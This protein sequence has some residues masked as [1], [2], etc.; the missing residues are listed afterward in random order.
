MTPLRE[1]LLTDMQAQ[2]LPKDIQERYVLE[3]ATLA[4]QTRKSPDLVAPDELAEFV[5]QRSKELSPAES[6]MALEALKFF[7]TQTLGR[8]WH[9]FPEEGP[10]SSQLRLRMI[11]DMRLRNLSP[12][13][14]QEYL[15]WTIK[16]AEFYGQS[17]AKLGPEDIRNWLVHLLEKEKK[18]I[19]TYGVAAAALRFL[20]TQTLGRQ[21]LL[22]YIPL[23]KREKRLPD[24]LSQ[25]E[26]LVFLN[27]ELTLRE[28][29]VLS[30]TY[31]GGL[32]TTEVSRL[33][34]TDIDSGRLVLKIVQGKGRKDRYVALSKKLLEDLRRYWKAYRPSTWLFPNADGTAPISAAEIRR[35]CRRAAEA[36][37]LTKK[38]TP[39]TLRHCFATHQL[40]RG[41]S[42][43]KI[44]L[45]MGHR[46]IRSTSVYTHVATSTVCAMESPL[47]WL[48]RLPD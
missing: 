8:A 36:A 35:I 21:W 6:A 19:S 45:A 42:L 18:S 33:K 22:H 1:H 12:K 31:A 9:E 13:T 30:T 41:Y 11:Q 25:E 28:M 47:D 2:N 40:E 7:F 24:I 3:V 48:P 4:R 34:V 37:G 23:P 17:P 14:Q 29:A 20:Y 44:Q 10:K 43:N 32:R 26:V 27:V 39:R 46:S 15:R 5:K 16:F 38:V